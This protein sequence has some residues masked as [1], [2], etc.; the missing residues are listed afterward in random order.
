[1][2]KPI[3]PEHEREE[4][5]LRKRSRWVNEENWRTSRKGNSTRQVMSTRGLGL[6]EVTIFFRQGYWH[7]SIGLLDGQNVREYSQM[8]H[9]TKEAAMLAAFNELFDE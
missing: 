5:R 1:M 4:A 9:D 2:V 3:F 7:W 6:V 8:G